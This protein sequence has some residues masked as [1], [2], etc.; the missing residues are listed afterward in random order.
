MFQILIIESEFLF[1]VFLCWSLNYILSMS[2]PTTLTYDF[3]ST[4]I[5]YLFITLE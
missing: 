2:L 3:F 4:I 5:I 1:E